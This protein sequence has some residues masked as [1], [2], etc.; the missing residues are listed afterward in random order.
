MLNHHDVI[1][2]GR[3]ETNSALAEWSGKLGI[4]FAGASFKID[5][6]TH[7]SEREALLFAAKNPLDPAHMVLVI[8]GNDALRTVKAINT[9]GQDTYVVYEDGAAAGATTGGRGGRGGR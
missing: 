2:V 8:A 5:G 6:A 1:F 7:A 3:P 9:Y 4:E